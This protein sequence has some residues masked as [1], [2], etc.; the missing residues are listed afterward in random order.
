VGAA[1]DAEYQKE[2]DAFLTKFPKDPQRWRW[3]F[4]DARRAMS[5]VDNREQGTKTAKAALAEVLTAKDVPLDLRE[6]ASLMNFKLDVF[7]HVPL[8]DLAKDLSDHNKAFPK[9]TSTASL[10]R[11]IVQQV[12]DGQQSLGRTEEQ[13][14]A[15]LR[16]LKASIDGPLASATADRL[17]ELETLLDLK[18]SPMELK[19]TDVEG[20]PFN[21]EAYRGKVVLIDFWATWCGPCVEGLPEVIDQYRKF[22]DQGL[23]IVGISFD[24]DK[25]ALQQFV[26]DKQMPW[27]QFF[28]GKAWD[29][30]YGRKYGIRAIP[31]MW[32]VGRDGRVV[33]F[34][35]RTRLTEKIPDLLEKQPGAAS[36]ATDLRTPAEKS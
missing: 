1:H 34:N 20:H 17:T 36:T 14:I 32:L 4:M 29:N 10:A 13:V 30:V 24:Q 35:A 31:A 8:S 23:E 25:Q 6:Q 2:K 19:F 12:V 15:R 7:N 5:D 22:H 9:S 26:K 3:N 16:E 27:I 28:D 18:T 11:G 33:D 21:L